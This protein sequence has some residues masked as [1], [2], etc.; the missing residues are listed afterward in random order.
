MGLLPAW[1]ATDRWSLAATLAKTALL[2]VGARLVLF[3]YEGYQ[4][5]SRFRQLRAQ[6]IV[7]SPF[8]ASLPNL[9]PPWGA[10]CRR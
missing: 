9:L 1:E 5:R 7:C 2:L 10:S 6:G 8:P 4:V 3:L